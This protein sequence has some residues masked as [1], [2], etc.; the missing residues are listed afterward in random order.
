MR[1]S[2]KNW[3]TQELEKLKYLSKH[4][5][6]VEIAEKLKR[7]LAAIR[8][9]RSRIGVKKKEGLPKQRF[10]KEHKWNY[11]YVNNNK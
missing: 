8:L 3:T 4:Y 9:K 7:P 11:L 6:D 2:Y 1:N 10:A 5:S